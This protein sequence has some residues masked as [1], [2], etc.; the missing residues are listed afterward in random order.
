MEAEY[1]RVT[2]LYEQRDK[3][4]LR[5]LKTYLEEY[6][7]T[8]FESELHFMMGVIQT[9]KGYYKR[10][11]R[12]FERAD[13]KDLER[14]HQP[15]YQFYKG[16]AH[17]M[18]SDYSKG[19]VYFG[20][21][22]KHQTP[23]KQKA[24]YYYA[25]CE[26]KAGNYEKALPSLLELENDPE[27]RKTVPYYIVQIRYAQGD[28]E[29]VRAKAEELLDEQPE[30]ENNGELHRMLGEIYFR[31]D[32][33]RDAVR[34]LKAYIDIF[35]AKKLEILRNDLYLLGVAQFQCKDFRDAIET[36]KRVKDEQDAISENVA[37]CMG[38]AYVQ[39]GDFEQAKLSYLAATNYNI[40]AQVHYEAMYNY[41]LAVYQSSSSIGES[42]SVFT[43]F[44]RQYPNSEH[45]NDIYML[46]SD[47]F[48]KAKNYKAAL[49]ALDSVKVEGLNPKVEHQI[50][51]TKQYL[52][53]QVGS[54][55]FVRGRFAEAK[56]WFTAVIVEGVKSEG[57]IVTDAYYWRAETNYRLSDYEAAQ[58]DVDSFFARPDAQQSPNKVMAD[59]LCGYIAFQLKQYDKARVAFERFV[60]VIQTGSPTY[61]DALNRI[62]DCYFNARNFAQAAAYYERASEL[63]TKSS[64]YALFQYGYSMGLRKQYDDKIRILQQLVNS[65]PKSDYADDELYEIARVRMTLEQHNEAAEAYGELLTRYPRS[66]KARSAS[67]ERAMAY[68]NMHDYEHAVEAYKFTIERYPA[69]Q[70][71]YLAVEGLEAVYVETNR[72]N[73]YVEY[74][75][76]LS[77]LNMQVA[78]KDD[79]LA[80][81]AAELQFRQ[82]NTDA[83]LQQYMPL[84]ERVGS[85]YA[86]PSAIAAAEIYMDR[87]DYENA[88]T[89]YRRALAL[90]SKPSNSTNA[91]VGIMQCAVALDRKQ[92]IIDVASQIL[93]EEHV[94]AD[95]SEEALY[96]RAKAYFATRQYKQ[97]LPDLRAISTDVR[98]S[99][100][101]E[102]KY[103]LAQSYFELK[104]SADAE[105]EVMSFA[106][107]PTQQQYWLARSLI[108]LAE[109]SYER[110]D[111]FQARQYLLSLKANYT[112]DDDIL[113]RVEE[114]LAQ[115]TPAQTEEIDEDDFTF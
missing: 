49:S 3:T 74:G 86:E 55:A 56:D 105:A 100:G 47:A 97:A 10:A 50:L 78:T 59:Y 58:R 51:E 9:E 34:E 43:D 114:H 115:W 83:A 39:L 17:L 24:M 45:V 77:K 46:L 102:S 53:Y 14:P 110:G 8:T 113:Q 111:D 94:A 68:R 67:I 2:K 69:S 57:T 64:D 112:N 79:S 40:D 81:A 15:Q 108:L 27:Y 73:E 25:Y 54:D 6:P 76:Q 65:Y 62:G 109:I 72:V 107:Q 31:Q 19:A 48:R 66:N 12:E 95:I 16:Y 7:Y 32:R 21:L 89:Y 84:S 1:N 28:D 41:C 36:F 87:K 61:Q 92:D 63:H 35:T 91:R 80:Y 30:N 93:A 82:G 71:A 11:I 33:F 29:A 23:Y 37:L 5:Q 101:A 60:A 42:E 52:R 103:L 106:Q 26:Y 18:L 96:Q 20:N 85:P 98:T 38:N 4:A 99:I 75:K 44:I 104:Q 22:M 88:L 13:Y 70:E 90:A